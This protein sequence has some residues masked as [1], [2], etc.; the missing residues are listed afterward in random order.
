MTIISDKK[1]CFLIRKVSSQTV[2]IFFWITVPVVKLYK[3]PN[4]FCDLHYWM[5]LQCRTIETA[6]VNSR[7]PVIDSGFVDK[8]MREN[9]I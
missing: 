7:N 1:H 6:D 4:C 8:K 2:V 5:L 3:K 9:A